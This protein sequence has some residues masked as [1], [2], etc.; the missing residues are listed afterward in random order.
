MRKNIA[1]GKIWKMPPI[2]T[3]WE[4]N[5]EWEKPSAE[6][7]YAKKNQ[8]HPP[9]KSVKTLSNLIRKTKCSHDH[10]A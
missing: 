6:V 7:P 2:E 5:H 1:K 9:D 3:S 8:K 10:T 4:K